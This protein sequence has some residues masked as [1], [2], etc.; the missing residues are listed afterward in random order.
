MKHASLSDLR[1]NLSTMLNAV[2][3]DHEPLVVTRKSGKPVVMVSL[4]D[5]EALGRGPAPKP[6]S[7]SMD[8]LIKALTEV[9]EMRFVPRTL[10]DQ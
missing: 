10:E 9:D 8:H 6:R 5:F 3:K 4:E 1:R 2:D 7:A